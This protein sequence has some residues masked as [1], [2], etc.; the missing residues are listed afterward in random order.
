MLTI[1][2][3]TLNGEIKKARASNYTWDRCICELIDNSRDVLV[4]SNQNEKKI[5]IKFNNDSNN[6]LKS[7]SCSDNYIKGIIDHHIWNWTYERDRGDGDCGEF[8]TGFKSGAVNISSELLVIT[9]SN[10]NFIKMRADWDEMAQH[11]TYTPTFETIDKELYNKYHPF[12]EGSSFIL[13]NLINTNI[14]ADPSQMK[15]DLIY[16]IK[17]V[18]KKLL[19]QHKNLSIYVDDTIINYTNVPNEIGNR[20]IHTNETIPHSKIY[21]FMN[22]LK[23]I[24]PIVEFMLHDGHKFYVKIKF[25]EGKPK[26]NPNGN[27]Y[28]ADARGQL[29]GAIAINIIDYKDKEEYVLMDIMCMYSRCIYNLCKP[30]LM[31][32][33][34]DHADEC[35]DPNGYI[36]LIRKDRTLSDKCTAIHYRGDGYA[37]YMYHELTYHNRL[38]DNP[39]GVQF[40]KNTDNKIQSENLEAAISWV[41]KRHESD[42][43]K[44]EEK[45][46]HGHKMH[47]VSIEC[48]FDKMV[49]NVKKNTIQKPFDLWVGEV[50]WENYN[51]KRL[52]AATKIQAIMRGRSVRKNNKKLNAATKIQ[53]IMRGRCVRNNMNDEVPIIHDSSD[54]EDINDDKDHESTGEEDNDDEDNKS[55]EEDDNDEEEDLIIKTIKDMTDTEL[56]DG[57]N[58]GIIK[59]NPEE[60]FNILKRDNQELCEQFE[61]ER[62]VYDG[63]NYGKEFCPD[64]TNYLK[65]IP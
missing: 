8:G 42:I 7:I 64:F 40:N 61:H 2:P 33:E 62:V 19:K 26:R 17:T 24:I 53:A 36:N 20:K 52:N 37:T 28:L 23:E 10:D 46:G 11:N 41:Q 63:I 12:D 15:N 4:N 16:K 38:M 51:N 22:K 55:T 5:F 39:L 43:E 29:R 31:N 9:S 30:W 48:E 18:Y 59:P 44:Y 54:G 14:P 45:S 25:K 58:K 50:N 3:P 56:I 49:M 34:I 47:M 1:A 35:H 13:K 60:I 65:N 21:V 27:I 57:L 32:G 6:N